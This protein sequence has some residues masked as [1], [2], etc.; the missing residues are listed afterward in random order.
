M[1]TTLD[2]LITLVLLLT[3]SGS[4]LYAKAMLQRACGRS[5]RPYYHRNDARMPLTLA[6]LSLY[7]LIAFVVGSLLFEPAK[8]KPQGLFYTTANT[9]SHGSK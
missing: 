4:C 3:Y 9:R 2:L 7:T 5:G 8:K 6:R 1:K